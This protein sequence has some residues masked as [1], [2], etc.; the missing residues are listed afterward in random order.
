MSCL[1]FNDVAEVQQASIPQ[2]LEAHPA[3]FHL[4]QGF[5]EIKKCGNLIFEIH[6]FLIRFMFCWRN[7]F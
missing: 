7:D 4:E 5:V 2:P 3:A 1:N 6:L